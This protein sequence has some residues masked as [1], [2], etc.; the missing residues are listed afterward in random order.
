MFRV[1]RSF[2]IAEGKKSGDSGGLQALFLVQILQVELFS[3]AFH[4]KR[5]N[6]VI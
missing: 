5:S 6:M 2:K 1:T 3:L 4:V